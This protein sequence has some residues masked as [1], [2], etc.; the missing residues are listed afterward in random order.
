MGP[1]NTPT[2]S[3]DGDTKTND[4]P[5]LKDSLFPVGSQ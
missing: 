3:G 4:S 1:R 2:S 5:L